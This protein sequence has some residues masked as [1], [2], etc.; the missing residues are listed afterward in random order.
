MHASTT[1]PLLLTLSLRLPGL[2]SPRLRLRSVLLG[3]LG[4]ADGRGTG[5]GG[6]AQVGA[7]SGSGGRVG[8]GLVGSAKMIVSC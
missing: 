3:T 6:G 2:G 5:D 7:V 4:L 8:D 1:P